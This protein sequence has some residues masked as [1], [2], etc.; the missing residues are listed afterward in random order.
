VPPIREL[1]EMV[2]GANVHSQESGV[3]HRKFGSAVLA[4]SMALLVLASGPRPVD[5]NS[6]SLQSDAATR[7][8]KTEG[9]TVHEPP[10]ELGFDP[11]YKKYLSADGL[12]IL[13]SERVPDEA[14]RVALGIINHLLEGHEDIRRAIIEAKVRVAIMSKDEQ[15][16]D[17][18]EHRDLTPKDYWNRRARGLGATKIRPATSCAEENLLGFEK[19][20]YKGESVLI[21]EFAHTIHEIGLARVDPEFDSRLRE[22]HG[23][24]IQKGLWNNTYAVTN[25]KEY[26][27]EGVQSWF[28]ANLQADPPNG[29]HNHVNTREELQAYDPDL[30]EVIRQIFRDNSWRWKPPA[31]QTKGQN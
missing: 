29:I 21:H 25:H 4:V 30:A 31:A 19:D 17:I 9:L 20:R 5:D 23:K 22:L 14:L 3:T 16:T 15:T 26:W 18:P 1:I 10:S 28:D 13:S 6:A 11:F 24:A 12:P 8:E 2:K 7:V 27:A